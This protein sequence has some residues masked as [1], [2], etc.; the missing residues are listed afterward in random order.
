MAAT[1]TVNVELL[2][3]VTEVGA[4]EA[5]TPAPDGLTLALRLTVPAMPL[6]SAVLIELMAALPCRIVRLAGL[7]LMEKSLG[8]GGTVTVTKVLWVAEASV[9]VTVTV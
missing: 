6:V 8:P 2:P 1:P 4:S 5:V 7:A 9:A 3:V